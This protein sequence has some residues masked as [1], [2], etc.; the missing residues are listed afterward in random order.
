MIHGARMLVA[1]AVAVLLLAG[2]GESDKIDPDKVEDHIRDQSGTPQIIEDVVCPDDVKTKE[3]ATFE[4]TLV[5]T[6]GSEESVTIRQE[7]DEGTIVIAGNRQTKLPED[8]TNLEILPEN[9]EA[10][11]RGS[12]KAPERILSVD[13]PAGIRLELGRR[14]ECVVRYTDKTEEIVE[15]VQRDKLGNVEI[16]GSRKPR[17]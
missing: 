1:T 9:V 11:I 2:C 5:L 3:G 14:F 15:I 16:A 7:D 8:R 17:D 4:C 6:D 10:L 12:A 13:C